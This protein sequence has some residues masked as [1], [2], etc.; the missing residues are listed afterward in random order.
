MRNEYVVVFKNSQEYFCTCLLRQNAGIVCKHFFCALQDRNTRHKYHISWISKRW[1]K[2]K[3]RLLS[4]ADFYEG[5]RKLPYLGAGD[6]DRDDQKNGSKQKPVAPP[7]TMTG[8]F[9]LQRAIAEAN[10]VPTPTLSARQQSRQFAE[11]VGS[12]KSFANTIKSYPVLAHSYAQ[13]V[14]QLHEVFRSSMQVDALCGNDGELRNPLVSV[15]KGRKRKSEGRIKASSEEKP[16][17]K[18]RKK[19]SEGRIKASSE[20]KPTKGRKRKLEGDTKACS[21]EKPKR[22]KSKK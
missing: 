18:G 4:D 19:K 10:T 13:F 8:V 1:F 21:V 14:H 2:E 17:K 7:G 11:V 15:T 16:A 22:K 12:S 5:L 6:Y 20:E 9:N 3:F